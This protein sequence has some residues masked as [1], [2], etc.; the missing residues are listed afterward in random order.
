MTNE[1]RIGAVTEF[2]ET[3]PI[4][5]QQII[6]KM[7]KDGVDLDTLT[8]DILQDY[9]QDHYGGIAANEAPKPPDHVVPGLPRTMA[10]AMDSSFHSATSDSSR[11]LP[12]A[13]SL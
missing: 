10:T 8:Q 6:D 1:K 3:H 11:F 7:R 9:D 12:F 13:V 5:E 2:Y 4:S